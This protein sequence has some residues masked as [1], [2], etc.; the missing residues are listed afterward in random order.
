MRVLV[1]CEFSGVVRDAFGRRGHDAWSCD[2]LES[3]REGQ[4]YRGDVLE[5]LAVERFDVMIAFPPCRYLA[6]SGARWWRS[7]MTEQSEAVEFVR[8]LMACS[9]CRIAIEN[10]VGVLSTA[11]RTPD[12]YIQPWEH[13]HGETKK[14]GLWLKN[15][16]PL[17]ATRLVD[18]RKARVH[19]VAPG[20][21][22]WRT[23]SRTLE[24]VAAA[25]ASQWG[26]ES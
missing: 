6:V 5:L 13:G 2:L 17:M 21:D 18:G 20:V 12:Q 3:E 9:V 1:A 25:M 10:P 8:L 19:G 11:Y 22:R 14:T 26:D 7:R 4:H 15:L 24:G 23:R 16:P